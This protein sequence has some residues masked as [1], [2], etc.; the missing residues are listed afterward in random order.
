MLL[1]MQK[2]LGVILEIDI[3]CSLLLIIKNRQ[4]HACQMSFLVK[5]YP[6]ILILS[7]N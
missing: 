4:D 6:F 5:T 2:R 1:F 7:L 3:S